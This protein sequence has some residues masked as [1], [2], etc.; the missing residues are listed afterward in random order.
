MNSL[1]IREESIEEA[2][3][4]A[5]RAREEIEDLKADNEKLLE[6]ARH[7]RE[8]ILKEARE[9]A[10]QMREK[11]EEEASMMAEKIVS[12]ARSSIQSE[13]EAALAEVRNLVAELSLE[14]SEKA[15]RKQLGDKKVQQELIKEYLKDIKIN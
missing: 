12:D 9:T 4:A 1:K 6:E 11:A 13:K 7:E 5:E 3:S 14:I 10:G 2:L 8:R 15:L